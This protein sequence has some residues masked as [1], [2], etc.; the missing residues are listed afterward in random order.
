M[1]VV[2]LQETRM[3][4]SSMIEGA[5]FSSFMRLPLMGMA[6]FP[7]YSRARLFTAIRGPSPCDLLS[8]IFAVSIATLAASVCVRAPFLSLTVIAAHGPHSGNTRTAIHQWWSELASVSSARAEKEVV[9]LAD[10]NAR[11][12]SVV[13][14]GVG[15][16]AASVECAA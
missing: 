1:H 15:D 14:D 12:G 6:V 8:T 2:G 10:C 11:L 16:H 4:H 7:C 3:K 5:L 13:S 9:V